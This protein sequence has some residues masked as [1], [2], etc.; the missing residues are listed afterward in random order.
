M[1]VTGLSPQTSDTG[2]IE[3]KYRPNRRQFLR[4]AGIVAAGGLAA[5]GA[6]ALGTAASWTIETA[7]GI[8]QEQ[9]G[10]GPRTFIELAALSKPDPT[11]IPQV[12]DRLAKIRDH[13]A[14]TST[15]GN[16]DGVASF[17]SLYHTITSNVD[18][19][20]RSGGFIDDPFLVTLDIT[21]AR[22]YLRA[23]STYAHDM[24]STPK[25]WRVIFDQRENPNIPP[26]NFAAAGVNAH[27]NYDLTFALLDTWQQVAPNDSVQRHDYQHINDSFAEEM[28]GLRTQFRGVP[29]SSAPAETWNALS[30][31]IC[32]T[33]VTLT[34]DLAWNEAVALRDAPQKSN[35]LQE[36]EH[37]LDSLAG[38]LGDA[39][40]TIPRLPF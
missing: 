13:A 8:G 3:P 14:A 24:N 22:R 23:I 12:L 31:G 17:T 20:E 35:A 7:L 19:T 21:F 5:A 29:G 30:N 33:I 11:S 37:R 15:R 2:H 34:R 38:T 28:N 16:N 1:S 4:T 27:I 25:C 36:A 40:L 9:P 6:G 26:E 32:D 10:P 18:H 39:I